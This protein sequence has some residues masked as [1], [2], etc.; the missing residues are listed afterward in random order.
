MKQ[1]F[2]V[3]NRIN[4]FMV[5]NYLATV[6]FKIVFYGIPLEVLKESSRSHRQDDQCPAEIQSKNLCL[7]LSCVTN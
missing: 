3:S 7:K 2:L 6:L 4:E 1:L 5:L